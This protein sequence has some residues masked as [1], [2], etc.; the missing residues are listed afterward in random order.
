MP[1]RCTQLKTTL[2]CACVYLCLDSKTKHGNRTYNTTNKMFMLAVANKKNTAQFL[3]LVLFSIH[4]V[5]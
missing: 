5:I 3:L 1:S 2:G 4:T